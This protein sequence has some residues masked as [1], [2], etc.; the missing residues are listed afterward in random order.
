MEGRGWADGHDP[1]RMGCAAERCAAVQV[2]S[3]MGSEAWEEIPI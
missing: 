2:K 1:T 3:R